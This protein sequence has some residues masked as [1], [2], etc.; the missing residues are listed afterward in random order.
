MDGIRIN[1]VGLFLD[2]IPTRKQECFYF[3]EGTKV[4]PVAYV[5]KEI[6]EDAKRLWGKLIG[7]GDYVVDKQGNRYRNIGAYIDTDT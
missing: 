3:S 7:E 6:L 2:K 5:R 1:G 4:Y